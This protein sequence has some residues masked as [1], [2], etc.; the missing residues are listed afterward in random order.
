M[1]QFD[2]LAA[3]FKAERDEAR[4]AVLALLD[5]RDEAR[6]SVRWLAGALDDIASQCSGHAGD[7]ARAALADPVVKR[8]A[9]SA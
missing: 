3:G 4:A 2:T 8:I 9:E 5:E 1:D 6:D 7:W